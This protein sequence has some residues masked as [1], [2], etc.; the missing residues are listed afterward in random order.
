MQKTTLLGINI[1]HVATV[2][3][4]RGADYPD[5]VLLALQAEQAGADYIT[6]HL[7]EDRRHIQDRDIQRLMQELSTYL[8]LEMAM[9]DEMVDI[10]CTLKPR[11]VC[12]VPEKRQE[13][14]TEGGLDVVA[15]QARLQDVV[16]QLAAVGI[17]VSLF[18][19][20]EIAQIEAAVAVAAPV[21]ELHT[22]HYANAAATRH[23]RILQD[24]T[25]AAQF[26]DAQGLIVNAGHGLTVANVGPIAAIQEIA[27][28][29]IGHAIVARAISL[30][31]TAAVQEMRD[32]IRT[33][34][35]GS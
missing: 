14:T 23:D 22:G 29:N 12:I 8:N 34:T 2:R 7:R 28:L 31:M 9:T 3:Q 35:P 21:V 30:G 27:E 17:R 24:I 4:A 5:P 19:A 11:D 15:N 25:E 16:G 6:A 33:A 18:I 1:D 13:L 32:A 20:P 10:A 26:A